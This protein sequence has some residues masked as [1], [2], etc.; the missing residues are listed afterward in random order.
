MNELFRRPGSALLLESRV[1]VGREVTDAGDLFAPQPGG[2]A[3]PRAPRETDVLGL[4]GVPAAAKELREPTPI[5]HTCLPKIKSI[6]VSH[7]M[8]PDVPA[9]A[10]R[11]PRY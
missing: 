7:G 3:W 1:V 4:Q 6:G 2:S 5:Q 11:L 8:A 10:H 9:P